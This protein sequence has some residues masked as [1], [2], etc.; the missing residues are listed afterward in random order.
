MT[1][2][3]NYRLE[4]WNLKPQDS[5]NAL[6]K[7]EEDK[8]WLPTLVFS[9]TEQNDITEGDVKSELI[10]ARQTQA[11]CFLKIIVMCYVSNII[12]VEDLKTFPSL[13]CKSNDN[14]GCSIKPIFIQMS[15]IILF[16]IFLIY[17]LNK[18]RLNIKW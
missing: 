7:D 1:D 3:L 8:I 18:I 4:F 6:S 17:C 13:Q 12:G 2:F 11:R 15:P 10:V 5:S 9:N 14:T 16:L